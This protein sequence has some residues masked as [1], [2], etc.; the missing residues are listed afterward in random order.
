MIIPITSLWL[1]ILAASI[2]VFFA[3]FLINA[4]LGFHKN[5]FR[6]LPDEDG[7]LTALQ[8]FEMPAGDYMMPYVRGPESLKSEELRGKLERGP[9]AHFTVMPAHA[10]T[11]MGPQ[12][13]QWFAYLVLVGIIV[14]YLAGRMLAPAAEYLDVFRL[15]GTV[16]FACYAMALMQRPIWYWSSWSAT[17]RSMF[18][19]LVYAVLTAGAFGWLWPS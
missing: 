11:S 13:V 15:T 14:A 8:R 6:K 3:S 7:V 4:V 9:V 16:A 17:L 18:D 2:L 5:D 1:P 12:L 10:M 19:G